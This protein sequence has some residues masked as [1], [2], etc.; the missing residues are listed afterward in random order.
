MRAGQQGIRTSLTRPRVWCPLS[1]R[2][3]YSFLLW[4]C[5]KAFEP[6]LRGGAL[7][8]QCPG[9]QILIPPLGAKGPWANLLNLCFPDCRMGL[10][11]VPTSQLRSMESTW[12]ESSTQQ[13]PPKG[14]H[15]SRYCPLL[16]P[17][18]LSRSQLSGV[19]LLSPSEGLWGLSATGYSNPCIWRLVLVNVSCT[20]V[21]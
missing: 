4:P 8:P 19:L 14:S 7:E 13:V 15:D 9:V 11:T 5:T 12:T 10:I 2:T 18:L 16:A 21:N 1:R 17:L 3:H 6:R 20:L